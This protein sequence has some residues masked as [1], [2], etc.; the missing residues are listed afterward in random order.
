MLSITC[1]R[2]EIVTHTTIVPKPA[3]ALWGPQ[4]NLP[5]AAGYLDFAG[6]TDS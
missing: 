3:V 6:N 5:G 2:I 4:G 1:L